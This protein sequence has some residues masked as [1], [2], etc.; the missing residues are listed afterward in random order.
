MHKYKPEC[1]SDDKQ[2]YVQALQ[3]IVLERMD[4]S[5]ELTDQELWDL[6]DAAVIEH[7]DPAASLNVRETAGVLC[8]QGA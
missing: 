6:I 8:T 2:E 4:V 7:R 5:R 1:K 3:G